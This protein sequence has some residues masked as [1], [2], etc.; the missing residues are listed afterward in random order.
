MEEKN[1]NVV[2]MSTVII[3]FITTFAILSV[4]GFPKLID[5]TSPQ[6]PSSGQTG[7]GTD[8]QTQTPV[9]KTVSGFEKFA[10]EEEFE[11]YLANAS[12]QNSYYGNTRGG[13]GAVDG[14]VMMEQTMDIATAPTAK[15]M[16]DSDDFPLRLIVFPIPMCKFPELMSRTL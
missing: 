14:M 11:Q 16:G 15:G 4:V 12:E 6:D 13:W 7:D 3:I 5:T 1:P 2:R 9:P 10:S 8:D